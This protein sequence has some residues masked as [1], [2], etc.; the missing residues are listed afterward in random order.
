M[1]E[2]RIPHLPAMILRRVRPLK[3]VLKLGRVDAEVKVMPS[4]AS[5]IYSGV[6]PL[7]KM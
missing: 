2:L 4:A 5:L 7:V 6:I 3:R 1:V